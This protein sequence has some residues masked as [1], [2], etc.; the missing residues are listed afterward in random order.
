MLRERRVP[1]ACARP[2]GP[3]SCAGW[4]QGRG[5]EASA[6]PPASA[7]P[8]HPPFTSWSPGPALV[9]PGPRRADQH[10][11]PRHRPLTRKIASIL[12]LCPLFRAVMPMFAVDTSARSTRSCCG[13]HANVWNRRPV[14][15]LTRRGH[16]QPEHATLA[17]SSP[18]TR[19]SGTGS[20]GRRRRGERMPDVAVEF[21][22]GLSHR[23][24]PYAS[25]DAHR[26][27]G[28][29]VHERFPPGGGRPAAAS[30]D[31]SSESRL[32]VTVPTARARRAPAPAA[33]PTTDTAEPQGR[34]S[35]PVTGSTG[36]P[37]D[38]TAS[39]RAPGGPGQRR[40]TLAEPARRRRHRMRD[41]TYGRR[42]VPA[43]GH[44]AGSR[45]ASSEKK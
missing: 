1:A 41:H 19:R 22:E 7:A 29:G 33:G 44:T 37:R 31:S 34:G 28:R 32:P 11:P 26:D 30:T 45:A 6:H 38:T 24:R 13:P 12:Q 15:R 40:T 42:V 14:A 8:D 10:V 4:P 16:R 2:V 17:G 20:R 39:Q 35:T 18:A 27:T 5:R 21:L 36:V 23:R 9:R 43:P 25:P 3:T